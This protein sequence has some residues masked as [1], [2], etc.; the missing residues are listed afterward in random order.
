MRAFTVSCPEAF[1]FKESLLGAGMF[2]QRVLMPAT[3]AESSTL[4]DDA[5]AVVEPVERYLG[6]LSAIER[7]PNTVRGY[8]I[9]LKLWFEFLA[10]AGVRWQHAGMEDVA[11]F[12]ASLGA[13]AEKVIVL[14]DAGGV[15]RPATVSGP[16]A[17]VFDSLII[18][19][20]AGPRSPARWWRLAAASGLVQAVPS[21]RDQGL[22]DR[23]AAGD[24]RDRV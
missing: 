4:L 8:A 23:H 3:G 15:R 14:A 2:V 6:Y 19:P 24:P 21:P 12:V 1:S 7:S 9:S 11:R 18:M 13:P 20:A 17:G 5:G 22:T 10:N 16:L